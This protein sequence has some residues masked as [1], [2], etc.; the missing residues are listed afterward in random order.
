MLNPRKFPHRRL[1]L[2]DR[3]KLQ[4]HQQ[5]AEHGSL[6]PGPSVLVRFDPEHDRPRG[7]ACRGVDL[8]VGL[9]RKRTE[10]LRNKVQYYKQKT[11]QKSH[12]REC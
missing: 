11:R 2:R 7:K 3:L 5:A 10:V 12:S 6:D 9:P 8:V 1:S 4:E